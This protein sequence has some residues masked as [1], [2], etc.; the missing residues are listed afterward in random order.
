MRITCRLDNRNRNVMNVAISPGFTRPR[1][2]TDLHRTFT[3]NSSSFHLIELQYTQKRKLQE[4]IKMITK[5]FV[6]KGNDITQCPSMCVIEL[7]LVSLMAIA[8]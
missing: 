8:W 2:T 6:G 1:R 3:S 7:T 4:A 5:V